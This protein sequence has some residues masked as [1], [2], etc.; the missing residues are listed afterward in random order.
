MEIST[1][2]TKSPILSLRNNM[3]KHG[4]DMLMRFQLLQRAFRVLFTVLEQSRGF[5]LPVPRTGL[6]VDAHPQA[7][8]AS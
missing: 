8:E 1:A 4:F 3:M 6:D 5:L 2:T 7:R